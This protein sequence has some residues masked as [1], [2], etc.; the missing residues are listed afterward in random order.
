MRYRQRTVVGFVTAAGNSAETSTTLF[1]AATNPMAGSLSAVSVW[2]S[3]FASRVRTLD[4]SSVSIVS[5][6]AAN[7]SWTLLAVEL[8][9][10]V[11]K[12]EVGKLAV[13]RPAVDKPVVGKPVIESTTDSRSKSLS[14]YVPPSHSGV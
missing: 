11:G 3:G 13:E 2:F 10:A 14:E 4:E 12:S 6:P 5:R 9:E 8:G 1:L 7:C